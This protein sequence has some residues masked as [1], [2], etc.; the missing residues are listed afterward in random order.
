MSLLTRPPPPSAGGQSCKANSAPPLRN[1]C[2][3]D[4]LR[5]AVRQTVPGRMRTSATAEGMPCS[6]TLCRA[7]VLAWQPRRDRSTIAPGLRQPPLRPVTSSIAGV[8]SSLASISLRSLQPAPAVTALAA[9]P[10]PAE[11]H[12]SSSPPAA[13]PSSGE[14]VTQGPAGPAAG[15]P[16]HVVVNFYHL[17]DI[18]DPEQARLWPHLL[19]YLC[20]L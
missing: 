3:Q 16:E 14:H 15:S 13:A 8:R 7:G 12:P 17:T 9:E 20:N 10:A 2:W 1:C 11:V 5:L 18:A 19:A 6:P 4:L